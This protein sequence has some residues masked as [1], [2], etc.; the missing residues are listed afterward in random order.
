MTKKRTGAHSGPRWPAGGF[1]W[2][3]RILKNKASEEQGEGA[4]IFEAG[5]IMIAHAYHT[6]KNREIEC[7]MAQKIVELTIENE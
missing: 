4:E 7:S 2:Q 3:G 6:T 1:S 5:N